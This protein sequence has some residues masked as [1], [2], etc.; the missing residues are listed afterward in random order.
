M[1]SVVCTRVLGGLLVF[2]V[3]AFGIPD[4]RLGFSGLGFRLHQLLLKH[5]LPSPCRLVDVAHPAKM[6]DL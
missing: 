2:P 1:Q 6:Q 3:W 5:G 4:F